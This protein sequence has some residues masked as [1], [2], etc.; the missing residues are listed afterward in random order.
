M[1]KLFMILMHF[2]NSRSRFVLVS[3]RT[4]IRNGP[5]HCINSNF[6]V[7]H[8][9]HITTAIHDCAMMI[10]SANMTGREGNVVREYHNV[11]LFTFINAEC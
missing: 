3:K 9:K 8:L 4:V 5:L 10:S 11:S 6:R 7:P 2:H 1:L